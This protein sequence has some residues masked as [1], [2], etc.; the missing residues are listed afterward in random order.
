MAKVVVIDDEPGIRN[1]IARILVRDGH[2]VWQAENGD[3]GLRMVGTHQP[4][5]VI[6]DLLMPDKEGIETIQEL[7]E[8]YPDLKILAVSGAGSAEEGGPLLDAEILGAD[9]SL[10]KPF[11]PQELMA[12]V[13]LLL[14]GS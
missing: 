5:L 8:A 2:E 10:P 4:Q 12:K 9:A 6:T 11:T 3:V 14:G 13:D 1:V 7:R